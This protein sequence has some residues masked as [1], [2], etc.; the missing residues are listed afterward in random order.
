MIEFKRFLSDPYR[1]LSCIIISSALI[2]IIFLIP[3]RLS[4]PTKKYSETLLDLAEMEYIQVF[5]IMFP[6]HTWTYGISQKFYGTLLNEAWTISTLLLWYMVF[7]C[8]L[9]KLQRLTNSEISHGMVKYFWISIGM[10]A[11][12]VYYIKGVSFLEKF[13]LL[14]LLN[15]LKLVVFLTHTLR[16]F[17]NN[18][19][20]QNEWHSILDNH[21]STYR[22]IPS[23]PNGCPWWT[24][25]FTST[26]R[27]GRI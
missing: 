3:S 18:L 6:I 12:S 23:I 4:H 8:V 17:C 10:V 9:P 26:S 25:S 13:I 7:P 27:L 20:I 5:F 15:R 24:T 14:K 22:Q 16:Y 19:G 1:P 21:S 11:L 2:A